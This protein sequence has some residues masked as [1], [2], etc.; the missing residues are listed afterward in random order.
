MNESLAS[1][2]N[3]KSIRLKIIKK[4]A[5]KSLKKIPLKITSEHRQLMNTKRTEMIAEG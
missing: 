2:A 4:A 1:R 3:A 5:K